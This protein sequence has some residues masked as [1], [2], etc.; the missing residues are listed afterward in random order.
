MHFWGFIYAPFSIEERIEIGIGQQKKL[1]DL[2][3]HQLKLSITSCLIHGH[4]N[5]LWFVQFRQPHLNPLRS[6]R[7]KKQPHHTQAMNL[8][9]E[10]TAE[11]LSYCDAQ[12]LTKLSLCSRTLHRLVEP[13][14]YSAFTQ[15]GQHAILLLFRTLLN[16][17][18]L[19]IHCKHFCGKEI[20]GREWSEI[21]MEF[22][23]QQN[24]DPPANVEFLHQHQDDPTTGVESR[25]K[26]M[27]ILKEHG[28]FGR[29]TKGLNWFHAVD[30]FLVLFENLETLELSFTPHPYL[31]RSTQRGLIASHMIDTFE[32]R[33]FKPD[34]RLATA[35]LRLRLCSLRPEWL[36]G[37]LP[38]FIAL[39]HFEYTA[40]DQPKESDFNDRI[41]FHA[42]VFN[43]G[44]INSR[45]CLESLI[46]ARPSI[47]KSFLFDQDR[48]FL[49]IGSLQEFE[50]LRLLDVDAITLFGEDASGLIYS[51]R[52]VQGYDTNDYA[53]E[54]R[55]LEGHRR[56]EYLAQILPSS[57]EH[58]TIRNCRICVNFH[59]IAHIRSKDRAPRLKRIDVVFLPGQHIHDKLVMAL[60]AMAMR[61]DIGLTYQMME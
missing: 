37:H 1:T 52:T 8:P 23:R 34:R 6:L 9:N 49:E 48:P 29:F 38:D 20:K 45:H 36:A 17:P 11:I 33:R 30:A 60:Q 7:P 27:S 44:L 32:E 10:I 40:T 28:W 59:I 41:P 16:R 31:R 4:V 26:I 12:T 53:Q 54:I 55:P 43:T 51:R 56:H 50:R 5:I 57:L 39:K 35:S 46:L 3:F 25:S 61:Y 58:L 15:T 47:L 2:T 24:V 14:L 22:H 42:P 21:D 13:I 18:E 19:G